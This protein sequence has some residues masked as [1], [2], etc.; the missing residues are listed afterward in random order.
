MMKQL[1]TMCVA[2]LMAGAGNQAR[3]QDYY[4][5]EPQD[6]AKVQQQQARGHK[7]AIVDS[8]RFVALG[9]A[10]EEGYF[11]LQAHSVSLSYSGYTQ[12]GLD[13]NRNFVLLQGDSGVVQTSSSW[14]YPGFNN[15]GGITL[16]GQVKGYR[17]KVSKKGNISISYNLV[18]RN[19]NASVYINIP[20]GSDYATATITPIMGRGSFTA[21][22][23]ISPYRNPNLHLTP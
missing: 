3:A 1:A 11:V 9:Q 18:G 13:G 7:Q 14:G 15:M 8:V 10:V 20:H 19:V 22:G 16:M 4:P 5:Q 23:R 21:T 17:A 12:S 6:A 2:L